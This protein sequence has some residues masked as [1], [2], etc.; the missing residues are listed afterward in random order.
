MMYAAVEQRGVAAVGDDAERVDD[1]EPTAVE[2]SQQWAVES[3]AGLDLGTA[4][5]R[6]IDEVARGAYVSLKMGQASGDS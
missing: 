6:S 2:P 4:R 1:G 5:A 3:A